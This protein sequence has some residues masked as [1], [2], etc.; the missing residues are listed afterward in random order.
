[1]SEVIKAVNENLVSISDTKQS[2]KGYKVFNPDWTCR[3]FQYGVG[4]TFKHDGY[5]EMCGRG[6]HF[7]QKASDCFDYYGFDSKN[8]VARVEAIGLV[9]TDGNKSVTDEIVI[10]EE[11]DWGEVLSIVNSGDGNSGNRNSGDCN[12]GDCNSGGCNSGDWNSGG[13]NSG[14]RNSG[15]C[16]SGD[17]NSGDW[18]SGDWN[19]GNRNSGIFC[20][21]TPKLK[22]FNKDSDM[23]WDDW[24][25]SEARRILV[26]NSELS[27]WI[28]ANNMSD[29]EKQ[30]NPDYETTGGYLKV[31]TYKEMCKNMWESITDSEKEVIT[32][33]PNFDKGIFEEITGIKI[34]D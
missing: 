7:C 34:S 32:N 10:L 20:T 26:W 18:N 30:D 21:E 8:K 2:I 12:S 14:N 13:C 28:Y 17:C 1:M 31:F 29:E 15:N 3:G 6:F 9:E 27:V 4:K 19:S 11:I 23:S 25:H 22:L 16:N 24:I 33:I 5:I